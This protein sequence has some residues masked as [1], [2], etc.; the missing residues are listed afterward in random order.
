MRDTKVDEYTSSDQLE[1]KAS[2]NLPVSFFTVY[3]Y[4]KIKTFYQKCFINHP[5]PYI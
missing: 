2:R 1:K 3:Y 4:H 5:A